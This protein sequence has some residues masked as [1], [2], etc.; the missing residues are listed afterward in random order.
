MAHVY[1]SRMNTLNL[2]TKGVW[3]FYN[4]EQRGGGGMGIETTVGFERY[5][6]GSGG[7]PELR[8]YIPHPPYLG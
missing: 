2:G 4:S 5:A 3:L 1:G 7:Q 8:G 6:T